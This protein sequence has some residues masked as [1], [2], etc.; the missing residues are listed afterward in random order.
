MR[1]ARADAF[2]DRI[3]RNNSP[4][5]LKNIEH[6]HDSEFAD[7][8]SKEAID[9]I[10]KLIQLGAP[11][12]DDPAQLLGRSQRRLPVEDLRAQ[13]TSFRQLTGRIE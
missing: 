5:R 2:E 12:Q 8:C 10:A 9:L 6:D 1:G 3:L 13:L 7:P 11:M 4:E